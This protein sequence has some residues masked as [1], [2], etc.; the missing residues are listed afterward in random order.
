M[1]KREDERLAALARKNA[2]KIAKPK[3]DKASRYDSTL[4]RKPEEDKDLRSFF[5]EMKKREF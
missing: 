1:S 5:D 4:R 3:G 2:E